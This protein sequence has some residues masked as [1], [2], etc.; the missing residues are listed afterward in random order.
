MREGADTTGLW[1]FCGLIERYR[2]YRINLFEVVKL[3][4]EVDKAILYTTSKRLRTIRS[5]T[6]CLVGTLGSCTG[7]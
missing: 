7:V 3:F 1:V 4:P 6:D 2:V 5:L